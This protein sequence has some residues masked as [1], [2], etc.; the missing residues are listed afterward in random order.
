MEGNKG[1]KK[2]GNFNSIINKIYFKK[3]RKKNRDSVR[4]LWENFKHAYTCIMGVPEGEGRE[5][6]IE[7]LFEKIM[8]K[9]SLTG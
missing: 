9:T 8:K 2:W 1:E 4:S 7:N 3:K 5:P 6:E